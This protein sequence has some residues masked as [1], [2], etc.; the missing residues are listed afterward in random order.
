MQIAGSPFVMGLVLQEKWFCALLS[1]SFCL[2]IQACFFSSSSTSVVLIC[3]HCLNVLN[4]ITQ[5][6]P[7][8]DDLDQGFCIC[9][10]AFPYQR[11]DT[12][13]SI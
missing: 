5:A 7:S 13:V 6:V 4:S 10:A 11:Q 8:L 3:R 12:F 1:L 9:R 2:A